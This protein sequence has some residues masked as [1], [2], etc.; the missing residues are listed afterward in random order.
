MARFHL[1][2]GASLEAIHLDADLSEKGM[3]QS[4]GVM[5]NYRYD[6]QRIEQNH[7]AYANKQEVIASSAVRRLLRSQTR[8]RS[9]ET[10]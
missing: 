5:V 6:P 1:G 9:K 4:F 8:A 3:A 2:N 10:A 7:E